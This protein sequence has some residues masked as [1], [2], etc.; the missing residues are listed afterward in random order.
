[1]L[2]VR[3]PL[4]LLRKYPA[5]YVRRAEYQ[6][7]IMQL[8]KLL[9]ETAQAQMNN[10]PKERIEELVLHFLS[11]CLESSFQKVDQSLYTHKK[12]RRKPLVL[13]VVHPDKRQEMISR[14]ELKRKV[15][16]QLLQYCAQ[17][18]ARQFPAKILITNV[19]E[20]YL[21]DEAR[22]Q[23]LLEKY[24]LPVELQAQAISEKESRLLLEKYLQRHQKVFLQAL[25][26]WNWNLYGLTDVLQE[27]PQ[28]VVERLLSSFSLLKEAIGQEEWERRFSDL[29]EKGG[30]APSV[31]LPVLEKVLARFTELNI[32]ADYQESIQ[33]TFSLITWHP[34]QAWI[35]EETDPQPIDAGRIARTFLKDEND[36]KALLPVDEQ[37]AYIRT[38][39]EDAIREYLRKHHSAWKERIR[40]PEDAFLLSRKESNEAWKLLREMKVGNPDMRNGYLLRTFVHTLV[41]F[42][43]KY[44]VLRLP[45]GAFVREGELWWD[46]TNWHIHA[47]AERQTILRK[48][49]YQQLCYTYTQQIFGVTEQPKVRARFG[50]VIWMDLWTQARYLKAEKPTNT[51]SVWQVALKHLY[52]KTSL[53]YRINLSMKAAKVRELQSYTPKSGQLEWRTAI[54]ELWNED[55]SFKGFDLILTQPTP[56]GFVDVGKED[57]SILK[58]RYDSYAAQGNQASC[59]VELGLSL[60]R[61][62]GSVM[63]ILPSRLWT[64]L[65]HQRFQ[66]FLEKWEH[67]IEEILVEE[68]KR[69]DQC[70]LLLH[71]VKALDP[72]TSK[73]QGLLFQQ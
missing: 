48:A 41:H 57:K 2:E 56:K 67:E 50:L 65:N 59:M 54:P 31:S 72:T 36:R 10:L 22:L 4:T 5:L 12:G 28:E 61:E 63:S 27:Q 71:P 60:L 17:L 16:I 73:N 9:E 19:Y 68:G 6:L 25:T 13:L 69:K 7:W 34:Q 42:M 55:A 32:E 24:S 40:K 43:A 46:G 39:I 20:W 8:H 30:S 37:H 44:G 47:S 3:N 14:R 29:P 52:V 21:F 1:M 66:D 64:G 23:H 51:L 49:L 53:P 11:H 33:R 45:G 70:L 38:H 26:P 18:N 15:F 58:L 35:I 62:S